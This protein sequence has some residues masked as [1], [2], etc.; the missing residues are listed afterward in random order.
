MVSGGTTM[1]RSRRNP[2]TP[3]VRWEPYAPA[4]RTNPW[5]GQGQPPRIAYSLRDIR[6]ARAGQSRHGLCRRSAGARQGYQPPPPPPP[7]PPPDE[8]PPPEPLL[9]PGAVEA[10]ATPLASDAPTVPAK[11]EGLDQALL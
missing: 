10:D 6:S 2:L 4:L 8:P 7:P 1:G 3:N 9:K 11:R 5:T